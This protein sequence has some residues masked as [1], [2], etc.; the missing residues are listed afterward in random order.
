MATFND[1]ISESQQEAKKRRSYATG[2]Q[3]E[4]IFSEPYT[5]EVCPCGCRVVTVLHTGEVFCGRCGPP[6]NRSIGPMDVLTF[7]ILGI[8][9]EAAD[10]PFTDPVRSLR[11]PTQKAP[12]HPCQ[13]C[14]D[15]EWWQPAIG[16]TGGKRKDSAESTGWICG[17]CLV[18]PADSLI[19]RF[20]ALTDEQVAKWEAGDTPEQRAAQRDTWEWEDLESPYEWKCPGCGS[21]AYFDR[22]EEKLELHRKK[23][24]RKST[25]KDCGRYIR[26]C[27]RC[28]RELFR[29]LKTRKDF[30]ECRQSVT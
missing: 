1:L 22:W 16:V 15:W 3:I 24:A 27:Q 2:E 19:A 23:G 4:R 13:V 11:R 5:G 9:H 17:G 14:G 20:Y 29:S 7:A 8:D 28:D 10:N 25:F 18:P 12:R 21:L 26:F 30:K 6:G